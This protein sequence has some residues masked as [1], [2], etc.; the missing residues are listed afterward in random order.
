VIC[1]LYYIRILART[2]A[3]EAVHVTGFPRPLDQ[4]VHGQD[5]ENSGPFTNKALTFLKIIPQSK[6][7]LR[8]AAARTSKRLP[9]SPSSTGAQ[10]AERAGERKE[11]KRLVGEPDQKLEK[12]EK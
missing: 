7:R 8:R 4:H 2:E 11:E 10:P 6:N 12:G 3:R 9:T 5:R 1:N